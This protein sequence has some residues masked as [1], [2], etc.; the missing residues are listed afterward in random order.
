ML[1]R[2]VFLALTLLLAIA[3]IAPTVSAEERTG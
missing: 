1:K 3:T 2:L